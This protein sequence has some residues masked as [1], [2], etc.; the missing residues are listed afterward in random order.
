[1]KIE[2]I[3]SVMLALK[4]KIAVPVR[5]PIRFKTSIVRALMNCAWTMA[6][7]RKR[8]NPNQ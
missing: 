5:Q 6:T 4:S 1:M 2:S 3:D 7:K 8:Q